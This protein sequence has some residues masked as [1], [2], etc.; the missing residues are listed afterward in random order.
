MSLISDLKNNE[1]D[2]LKKEIRKLKKEIKI[3]K[4][5]IVLEESAQDQCDRIDD[6]LFGYR[7]SG[8]SL[9]EAVARLMKRK[10]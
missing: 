1:I 2:K 4:E 6:I 8:E 5:G 10:K 9:D 7:K 3:L